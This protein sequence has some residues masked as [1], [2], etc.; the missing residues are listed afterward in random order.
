[1]SSIEKVEK[2]TS[3][4]FL[5]MVN[6]PEHYQGIKIDDEYEFS[7]VTNDG[8]AMP[9]DQAAVNAGHAQMIATAF[10]AAL[11]KMSELE[12]TIVIDTPLGRLDEIHSSNMIKYYPNFKPQV[13]ILYQPKE[14][15]SNIS[16][17][18]LHEISGYIHSEWEIEQDAR[19]EHISYV[20][21]VTR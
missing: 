3:E 15:G 2:I 9:T 11:N 7:L 18:A 21:R 17:D 19:N 10:I 8:I 1:M 14:L 20:K 16:Q 13:I 6:E 4:T 5:S 12:A